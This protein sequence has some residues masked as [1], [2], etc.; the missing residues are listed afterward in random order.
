MPPAEQLAN[1]LHSSRTM[2]GVVRAWS[3]GCGAAAVKAPERQFCRNLTD[4]ECVDSAFSRN[5]NERE[6]NW[7]SVRFALA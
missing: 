1:K 6:L 4:T 2:S 3:R 5:D 7:R